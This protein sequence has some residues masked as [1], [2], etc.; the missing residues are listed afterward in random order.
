MRL[1]DMLSG[2]AVQL[3]AMFDLSLRAA[4]GGRMELEGWLTKTHSIAGAIASWT[5][6]GW[7]ARRVYSDLLIPGIGIATT[8]DEGI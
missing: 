4:S 3:R 6:I 7:W 2:S 5:W 8:G 1:R